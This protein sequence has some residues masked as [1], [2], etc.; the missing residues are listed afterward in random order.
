MTLIVDAN[1]AG[2]AFCSPAKPD[3]VPLVKALLE[4]RARLVVGGKLKREYQKNGVAWRMLKILDQAG[5][6]KIES[7]AAVDNEEKNV[8]ANYDLQSDDPHIL[9]LARVS[10]ARLLCSRDQNLHHD[11]RNGDIISAPRGNIYQVAAHAKL[12]R[13]CCG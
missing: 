5:R 6:T 1:C 8:K 13:K 12:I 4:G 11:F 2:D 9:A 7:D 3:F 10:G